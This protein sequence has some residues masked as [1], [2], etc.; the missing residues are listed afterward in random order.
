MRQRP[1]SR[2]I[3]EDLFGLD[4]CG[5][6]FARRL[7]FDG[8]AFGA[9]GQCSPLSAAR[10]RKETA[11][12]KAAVAAAGVCDEHD[13]WLE[14]FADGVEQVGEGCV[15]GGLGGVGTEGARGAHG[16]DV[17]LDDGGWVGWHVSM[18]TWNCRGNVSQ[19]GA[20][21]HSVRGW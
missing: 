5:E 4:E 15:E 17:L 11:V 14:G 3:L 2:E 8:S 9:L 13:F 20:V 7:D 19:V 6:T 16:H 1:H 10:H 18:I 21:R 12:D